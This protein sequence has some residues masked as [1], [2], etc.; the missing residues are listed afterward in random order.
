MLETIALTKPNNITATHKKCTKCGTELPLEC[1]GIQ[2]QGIYG[3]Q[4]QCKK[5][6]N[7]WHKEFRTRV[8]KKVI[9]HYGGKC[10]CCGEDRYEFLA[11][12]HIKGNGNKHRKKEKY[13]ELARWLTQ[14]NYPKGYRVLCHNCNMAI[15][16]HGYCPHQTK[17]IN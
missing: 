9:S 5:C 11:I 15:G 7:L 10:E 4:A 1:F 13:T 14:N 17:L 6:K 2:K 3:K 12:D 16:F 8:R